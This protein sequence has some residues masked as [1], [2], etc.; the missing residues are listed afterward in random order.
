MDNNSTLIPLSL[1]ESCF[2][3]YSIFEGIPYLLFPDLPT[4]P[5]NPITGLRDDNIQFWIHIGLIIFCLGL[6]ILNLI[7][8][9]IVAI[10]YGKHD[11][12]DGSLRVPLR[13]SFAISQFLTG[14]VVFSVTY[15]LQRHFHR[16]VNIIMYCFFTLHYINRSIVDTF[17]NRHSQTKVT[18]WI[19][20]LATLTTMFYHYINAQ[21]IGEARFCNG[22][23]FDPRFIIGVVIFATGFVLNRVSDAQLILLRTD[24]KDRNYQIPSGCSF[25]LISCPNYLGEMIEWLG[26][27]IMT[28]S[29]SAVVWFLFSASTFIPRAR[30]HH[31]WYVSH[32]DDY[33]P[34]RKALLPLIY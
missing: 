25:C 24:Y 32:F 31:K 11:K 22:Y 20:L 14:I 10:P 27:V 8:Q 12:G 19:P 26:W 29:L 18:I 3:R 2:E 28:W 9:F 30:H 5:V 33:P 4:T 21:F 23:Y 1:N 34:R 13:L 15:F 16:P 7:I 6:A 17:A